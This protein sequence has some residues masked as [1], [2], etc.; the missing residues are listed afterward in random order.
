MVVFHFTFSFDDRGTFPGYPRA[1]VSF[2][3]GR[4][5]VQLF[6]VISGFVILWSIQR[7]STVGKFAFSRFSRLFPPYWA[8]LVFV[9]AYILFAQHVLDAGIGPLTFTSGQ[10]FANITMVPRWI[11]PFR[12]HEVDS[13]YWTL[14]IEMGFYVIIGVMMAT[15]LTRKNRIV[16]VMFSFWCFDLAVNV[17]HFLSS[18]SSGNTTPG[19]GDYSNLFLAGMA[20]FLLFQERDRPKRDRQILWVIVWGA[21]VLEVLR[22]Q[23]VGAVV[24]LAVV[25]SVYLAIFRS[26][27]LLHSRSLQWL[28]GISYSLYLMHEFPGYITMKLLLDDGWNRNLVVVVAI[29]QSFVLAIILNK[30]V[31]KPVTRWLR[32]RRMSATRVAPLATT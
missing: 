32:Q 17:L 11:P 21:P 16:P 10:W 19:T 22:F 30:T 9:S 29:V 27:P 2:A 23:K 20:L 3:G 31:E 12:F 6:F 13:A 15:G 7:Q 4:Y 26:I 28:G 25:T 24:V 8:S 18:V 5:G 1:V 14:A